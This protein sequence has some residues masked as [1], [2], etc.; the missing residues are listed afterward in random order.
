MQ[1]DVGYILKFREAVER[2]RASLAALEA[3]QT[4]RQQHAQASQYFYNCWPALERP[5]ASRSARIQL[6]R[7]AM[8]ARATASTSPTAA[9][10]RGRPRSRSPPPPLARDLSPLRQSSPI[11]ADDDAPPT[12]ARLSPD[13]TRFRRLLAELRVQ[14]GPTFHADHQSPGFSRSAATAALRALVGNSTQTEARRA[15]FREIGR[16]RGQPD[17]STTTR[18]SQ[19]NIFTHPPLPFRNVNTYGEI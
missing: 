12:L 11:P 8:S 15:G 13:E 2:D 18:A 19:I 5:P 7:I 6:H 14:F 16:A 1:H 10:G 17:R 4:G 3:N 9:R